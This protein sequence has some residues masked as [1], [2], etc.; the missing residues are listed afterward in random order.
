MAIAEYRYDVKSI[1]SNTTRRL[2][3]REELMGL[4]VDKWHEINVR[5]LFDGDTALDK[6]PI[7][8]I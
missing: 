7:L 3:V 6:E 8:V 4:W 2:Q 5:A 1:E